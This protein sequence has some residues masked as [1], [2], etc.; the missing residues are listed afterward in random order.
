MCVRW[1]EENLGIHLSH[2]VCEVVGGELG[3]T[4][5]HSVGEVV[6]G[7]LGDTPVPQCVHDGRRT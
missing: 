4:P 5:L 7:E 3:D 2:S 1:S 6:E